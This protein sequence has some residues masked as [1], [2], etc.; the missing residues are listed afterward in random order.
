MRKIINSLL[1]AI[2][3]Y[4][5]RYIIQNDWYEMHDILRDWLVNKKHT[6]QYLSNDLIFDGISIKELITK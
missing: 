3:L 2:D 6:I 4:S 5:L 1:V